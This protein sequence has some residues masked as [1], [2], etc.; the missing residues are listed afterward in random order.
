M[1]E[2]PVELTGDIGDRNKYKEA[3]FFDWKIL[4]DPWSEIEKEACLRPSGKH[5]L[6]KVYDVEKKKTR[7]L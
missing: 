2:K 4:I 6:L 3:E 1:R 7:I 5:F